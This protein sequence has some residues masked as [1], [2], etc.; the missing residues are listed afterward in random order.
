MPFGKDTCACGYHLKLRRN[1]SS[2]RDTITRAALPEG[3][4]AD[5]STYT[6]RREKVQE[7]QSETRRTLRKTLIVTLVCAGLLVIS[8]LVFLM[9][10]FRIPSLETLR[11]NDGIRPPTEVLV[12]FHPYYVDET[13]SLT[14]PTEAIRREPITYPPPPDTEA[15]QVW[16]HFA[17]HARLPVLP[18]ERPLFGTRAEAVLQVL[19][20]QEG[21]F[22]L[23]ALRR[24][25]P[26]ST[27]M[28]YRQAGMPTEEGYL[29]GVLLDF[30]GREEE[31]IRA[32]QQEQEEY[33]KQ[34][35]R[36]EHRREQ[37]EKQVL[38]P[39]AD[40]MRAHQMLR[41]LSAPVHRRIRLTGRLGFIPVGQDDLLQSA[42]R[43]GRVVL[44]GGSRIPD[45]AVPEEAEQETVPSISSPLWFFCPVIRVAAFAFEG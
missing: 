31:L 12:S 27:L 45:Q 7:H 9:N 37:L 34:Y 26:V 30:G 3:V 21:T 42:T 36:Y 43:Y 29:R 6:S 17:T 2:L 19:Q 24:A 39:H 35:L 40:R 14:V 23:E 44:G 13:V 32:I 18:M 8:L 1:L 22:R 10:V 5:G 33:R 20:G 41:Q 15:R 16:A 28:V 38:D 4:R 11:E 25:L